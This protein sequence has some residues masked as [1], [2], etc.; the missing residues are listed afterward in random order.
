MADPFNS[1]LTCVHIAIVGAQ[2][3]TCRLDLTFND[4]RAPFSATAEFGPETHQGCC[5]GFPV[6]GP[7]FSTVPPLHP[8]PTDAGMDG[9]AADTAVEV[10][11]APAEV[12]SGK[13]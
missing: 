2:P 3:G 5:H 11:D 4:E 9:G 8:K 10:L 13:G 12:D 1:S 6:V 7:L